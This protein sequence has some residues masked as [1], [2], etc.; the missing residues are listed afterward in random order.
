M[1]RLK[2]RKADHCVPLMGRVRRPLGQQAPEAMG[3]DLCGM[4]SVQLENS[5]FSLINVFWFSPSLKA[6]CDYELWLRP[7]ARAHGTAF[8]HP[9]PAPGLGLRPETGFRSSGLPSHCSNDAWKRFKRRERAR[10]EGGG[11]SR[12]SS[13]PPYLPPSSQHFANTVSL[14]CPLEEGKHLLHVPE[15]G[16]VFGQG[17]PHGVASP[18]NMTSI[19]PCSLSPFC[20]QQDPPRATSQESPPNQSHLSAPSWP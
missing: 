1:T 18:R 13:L 12:F 2:G 8:T 19:V 5:C 6:G 17:L 11:E 4:S 20:P 16:C 14:Q 10:R 7:R 15:A 3:R 9:H